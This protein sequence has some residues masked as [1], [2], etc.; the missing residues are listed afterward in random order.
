M[1]YLPDSG[2]F[3]RYEFLELACGFHCIT[4]E[5]NRICYVCSAY[6][7]LSTTPYG[8][9]SRYTQRGELPLPRYGSYIRG[10]TTTR[11][12]KVIAIT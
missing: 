6:L 9:W 11:N 3:V 4:H 10:K 1:E 5:S 12:L 8:V 7:L 2:H